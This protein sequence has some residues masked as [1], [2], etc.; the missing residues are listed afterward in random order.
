VDGCAAG[1]WKL[2]WVGA[3]LV[4]TVE[5]FEELSGQVTAAL[6]DEVQDLGR[7]YE[8]DATLSVVTPAMQK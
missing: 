5:P 7:F 2:K 8:L 6:E 4:V 1:T 3:G